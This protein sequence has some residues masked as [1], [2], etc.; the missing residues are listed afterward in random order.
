MHNFNEKVGSVS[1]L[2][3]SVSDNT[4]CI[5]VNLYKSTSNGIFKKDQHTPQTN[6]QTDKQTNRHIVNS[7]HGI[8][9]S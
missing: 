8:I 6:K 7:N 5:L 1:Q 4:V 3:S 2:G 9:Q